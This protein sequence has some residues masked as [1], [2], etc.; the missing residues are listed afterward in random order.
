MSKQSQRVNVHTQEIVELS[1]KFWLF[2][3]LLKLRLFLLFWFYFFSCHLKMNFAKDLYLA[4][5]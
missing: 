4:F 3:P 5:F 2:F 1:F